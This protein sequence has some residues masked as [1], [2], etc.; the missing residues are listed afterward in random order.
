M[1]ETFGDKLKQMR[2]DLASIVTRMNKDR[3]YDCAQKAQTALLAVYALGDRVDEDF[4][5]HDLAWNWEPESDA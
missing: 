1:A 3:S 5:L 2:N 4:G